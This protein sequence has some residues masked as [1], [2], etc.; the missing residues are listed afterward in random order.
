[1]GRQ[2]SR[3]DANTTHLAL[4]QRAAREGNYA[5]VNDLYHAAAAAG[6]V[7]ANKRAW[8]LLLVEAG[9]LEEGYR[10][11]GRS[12]ER[13]S[14]L[15]SSNLSSPEQ[16]GEDFTDFEALPRQ[17][18]AD[19]LRSAHQ[20]LISLFRRWFAGRGDVYARQWYDAR[21]DRTGYVPVREPLDDRQIAQH[22][23]GRITLG[24]YLLYPDHHVSFAVIDLDPTAA[25]WER[26]R[27]ERGAELGG[28]GLPELCHYAQRISQ[29]A[30]DLGVP[31]FL[32]DTG[33][34]GL[35]LWVF[36]APRVPARRARAFLRELLWRSGSQPASVAAEIF[37]KQDELTGKGFGNLVKLPLGIHQATT[38]PSRFLN[39][40]NLEPELAVAALSAIQPVDP[41]IFEQILQQRVIP[42]RASEASSTPVPNSLLTTPTLG[43]PR[44]LAEALASIE[45]GKP[46]AEA[47]DRVVEGCAVIKELVRL[48]SEGEPVSTTALRCLLY[49][50]GLIGRENPVIDQL[51]ARTGTSRKELERIRRGLQSPIGCK[52]LHEYFPDLARRCTCPEVPEAGY[53]TPVLF[54]LS[55]PPRFARPQRVSPVEADE[56][57]GD[58][59][60]AS[61]EDLKA[62]IARLERMEEI[63]RNFLGT[64]PDTVN[65]A[66]LSEE[67]PWADEPQ[68]TGPPV[69]QGNSRR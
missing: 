15:D 61:K 66:S 42:L 49:S 45:S 7:E 36:F 9:N 62:I 68:T 60:S 30:R 19:P 58:T 41:A 2:E 12:A 6:I 46:V 57:L 63:L 17:Q 50:I 22:L 52:R 35:H 56:W 51:L 14:P 31:V 1:M 13:E 26:A 5:A 53:A 3:S 16:T 18:Q 25:A 48:A 11:C 54:A 55:N 44:A 28:L 38:R 37:P 20:E 39:P 69:D 40:Q 33:G 10:L 65:P 23:E 67:P 32:E 34:S 59:P 27:L 21:N 29:V 47:V 24:Q 43:S 64:R 8:G 4:A